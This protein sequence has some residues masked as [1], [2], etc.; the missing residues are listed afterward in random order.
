MSLLQLKGGDTTAVTAD[1]SLIA[2]LR[3]V[4]AIHPVK[5]AEQAAGICAGGSATDLLAR[6]DTTGV[7]L[8]PRDDIGGLGDEYL[9]SAAA[10][11]GVDAEALQ[12]LVDINGAYGSGLQASVNGIEKRE[13][14]IISHAVAA[15]VV[16]DMEPKPDV[17]ET[18]LGKNM[19][20]L[21][22]ADQLDILRYVDTFLA[23]Y[24]EHGLD[25]VA[26]DPEELALRG[27]PQAELLPGGGRSALSRLHGLLQGGMQIAEAMRTWRGFVEEGD[28][29]GVQSFAGQ[30][31]EFITRLVEGTL[32][33]LLEK[34]AK[35]LL[36]PGGVGAA[37]DAGQGHAMYMW[38]RSIA[39]E[40]PVLS[41]EDPFTSGIFELKVFNAG[42]GISAHA[43]YVDGSGRD[44]VVPSVLWRP[45]TM[46]EVLNP[47]MWQALFE[48]KTLG[49]NEKTETHQFPPAIFGSGGAGSSVYRDYFVGKVSTGTGGVFKADR[50]YE[51]LGAFLGRETFAHISPFVEAPAPEGDDSEHRT[52][53]SIV[54]EERKNKPE[55]FTEFARMLTKTPQR[56]GVCAMKGAQ[57]FLFEFM[58]ALI[59]PGC[60]RGGK[61]KSAPHAGAGIDACL[62]LLTQ[63]RNLFKA[64]MNDFKFATTAFGMAQ[65]RKGGGAVWGSLPRTS[66]AKELAAPAMMLAGQVG[67]YL[68]THG[69][70]SLEKGLRAEFGWVWGGICMAASG[71]CIMLRGRNE[72]VRVT[73]SMPRPG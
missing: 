12:E 42:D 63:S 33:P 60:M 41:T 16:E 55:K 20:D 26:K 52:L 27:L 58:N 64:L 68:L 71:C 21:E 72:D 14:K 37:P 10:A 13:L 11:P 65:L 46:T 35:E 18:T 23:R 15:S 54:E 22:G 17:W 4:S 47:A 9:P 48:L 25:G 61:P 31:S 39:E 43:K 7:S 6:S 32:R 30:Y 3:L 57:I 8:E 29:F 44:H 38:V 70:A 40:E 49:E 34:G 56:A 5:V 66:P 69:A 24:G 53:R 2:K 73:G 45:L 1:S 59:L 19:E 67:R 28:Y 50:V 36:F 62:H 51:V